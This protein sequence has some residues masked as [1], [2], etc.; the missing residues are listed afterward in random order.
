MSAAKIIAPKSYLGKPAIQ[1]NSPTTSISLEDQKVW[2]TYIA[3]I[4]SRPELSFRPTKGQDA[5]ISTKLDL[6]GMTVQQAF[7]RVSQFVD[8]HFTEGSK[9]LII[10]TGK[11]GKIA[12]EFPLWCQN[13]T[14]IRK[15]ESVMDSRG[16]SG[17]WLIHLR[18]TRNK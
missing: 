2:D 17:A 15:I 18:S 14:Q 10:V 6:H 11:S 7:Y 3:Q 4:Y 8:E 12:D 5:G 13:L 9:L 16:E 1:S